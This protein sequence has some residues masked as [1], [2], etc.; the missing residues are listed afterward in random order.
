MTSPVVLVSNRGP[1]SFTEVDGQLI[2]KRG[3]GGLV[4]GL[5]PLVTGTDTM[6]IAAA[7][8]PG[9]RAAASEGVIDAA[10]MRVRTLDIDPTTFRLA[11][12]VVCNST[13]WF[14]HHGLH[15]L[16]RR[17]VF[18][19]GWAEAW[20]AYRDY[21]ERFAEVV[22]ADAPADATVL[23]QDY[24][25]AL[26]GP[27]LASARPDLTT[28]HFSH[29]PFAPPHLL[30]VMPTDS[31]VELLEGMAGHSTCGFHSARWAADYQASC[32]ELLGR[33]VPAFVSP[34]APDPDDMHGVA[35]SEACTA[36][37][38]ELDA[39]LG[40]RQ[41]IVRV[42]RIELS[43]NLLRGFR[44]FDRLLTDRPDLR[45]R[46]VFRALGYTSRDGLPEY[47]AYRQ[48]VEALVDVINRRWADDAWTPIELDFRDDFPR[49]VAHLRRY[50]VL[51]INPIR[52]G[53]NLVA[54]EGPIV[55]ERDGT[56]VLSREAGIHD[57]LEGACLSVNPYD[58][59]EQ[60]A[61]LG[62]A[63]DRSAAERASAAAEL[64]ARAH[65]R[66]P[67]DWFADQLDAAS[68]AG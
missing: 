37:L 60:A 22:A 52:D 16:S 21:N 1:V 56:L 9:D 14:L 55:N 44:A 10:D 29:T 61:A 35:S 67:R 26:V 38:G 19:R 3:G 20:Q 39:G 23:V 2:A 66:T 11:Y 18:D 57:E 32:R 48:E 8:S 33:E 63:L 49:S 17:P 5:A 6:W 59:V 41:L 31:A 27:A 43:K 45:G 25:L 47:L 34:L 7:L 64:R 42:D 65:A 40:D 62:A 28:V 4:S 50:D 51:L 12:D 24:H 15:D 68:A 46:V 30:R 53:L 54:K 36:A 58:I 13:L